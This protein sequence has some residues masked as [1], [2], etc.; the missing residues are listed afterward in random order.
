VNHIEL[1]RLKADMAADR[2]A[3]FLLSPEAVAAKCEDVGLSRESI[4]KVVGLLR[5]LKARP[6]RR[7]QN[8]FRGQ[9]L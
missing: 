9:R 3:W 6:R 1:E 5:D 2:Q 4:G 8:W 7:R